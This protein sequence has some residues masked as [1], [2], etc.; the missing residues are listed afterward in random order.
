MKDYNQRLLWSYRNFYER[1][2]TKLIENIL[3]SGDTFVD[4]GANAGLFSIIALQKIGVEGKV[5]AFEGDHIALSSLKKNTSKYSNID[6][7]EDF[8]GEKNQPLVHG[9]HVIEIDNVLSEKIDVMKIDVDGPELHVLRGS[10]RLIEKY[11]PTL[12]IEISPD[13]P[14]YHNIHFSDVIN[15]LERLNYKCYEPN[16]PFH[17]FDKT[18][19]N[20]VQNIF[21]VH[22]DNL[23]IL[24]SN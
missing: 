6:I 11:K 12:L 10:K 16:M 13:S 9:C 5:I 21:C 1:T 18:E 4:V 20:Q 2:E 17:V 19:I 3:K 15:F 7:I 23:K 14:K 24:K 22:D 8:V